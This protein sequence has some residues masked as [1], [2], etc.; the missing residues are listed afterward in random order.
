MAIAAAAAGCRLA[1]SILD[2]GASRVQPLA[3]PARGSGDSSLHRHGLWLFGV[4][5]PARAR[6]GG[7][8]GRRGRQ[9][10]RLPWRSLDLL[11]QARHHRPRLVRHRLRLDAVRSRLDVH[12]VLCRARLVGGALGR[13][14]GARRS[15]QGRRCRRFLLG[16]RPRRL[17]RRR[18]RPSAL[19]DVAGRGRVGRHRPGPRLHLARFDLGEVVPRP[20]RHGD[21]HGDHGV[22]RAAR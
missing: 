15:A 5:G 19:A 9:A 21:R 8:R 13:L 3:C 14:A 18:L 17:R 22:W 11:G 4:L 1:G 12:P 16:R 6:G 2:R 10:D 7:G 20:A